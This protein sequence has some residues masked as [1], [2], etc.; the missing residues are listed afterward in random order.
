MPT[1]PKQKTEEPKNV[2]M[3]KWIPKLLAR[4]DQLDISIDEIRAAIK[5]GKK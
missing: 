4:F 3:P 2:K 1:T 5:Y